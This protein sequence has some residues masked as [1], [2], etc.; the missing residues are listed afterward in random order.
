[1]HKSAVLLFLFLCSK[2][3]HAQLNPVNKT[4]PAQVK[5]AGRQTSSV[6]PAYLN[7]DPVL[8]FAF[9]TIADPDCKGPHC[10][11]WEYVTTTWQDVNTDA[12]SLNWK[13]AL[14]WRHIPPGAVFGKY[15]ISLSPFT[16]SNEIIQSGII[17]TGGKDSVLFTINYTEPAVGRGA[18]SKPVLKPV[19]NR[20]ASMQSGVQKKLIPLFATQEDVPFNRKF[21]IRITALNGNKNTTGNYSNEVW[22]IQTRPYFIKPKNQAPQITIYDDYTITSVKY[23]P[24]HFPEPSFYGCTVVTGY[25]ENK[26]EAYN[27]LLGKDFAQQFKQ[28]YPVGKTICPHYDTEGKP[29]YKKAFN[30]VT[31]FVGKAINGA[32][33]FYNDTKN[34]VKNKFADA[35]CSDNVVKN[36]AAGSAGSGANQTPNGLCKKVA[37]YAFDGAMVAA[38]IPP[39]LPNTDD[40]TKMAEGQLVDLACDKMEKESGIPVPDELREEMRKE[41]HQQ[42]QS[43]SSSRMV[44]CGFIRVKPHPQGFFQTAW[45]EIEVTRTSNNYK[46]KAIAG[47]GIQD[48]TERSNIYCEGC[49]GSD[50]NNKALSYNLFERAFT[51][52]PFLKNTGDKVKLVV[53]LKPQESWLQTNKA[54]GKYQRVDKAYPVNEWVNPVPPTYEGAASSSGFNTLCT[55][56]TIRFD[57]GGI[58]VA[59]GVQTIFFHK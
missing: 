21:Y 55:Q 27:K 9:Q 7:T 34:Y 38:G 17:E 29:W 28:A 5:T 32:S 22:L 56:S 47:I 53:V 30:G 40:L 20:P 33:E 18:G 43:S 48:K 3:L 1:M 19:T 25:D 39:S 14:L 58:K 2:S 15:E 10:L 44:D 45:L 8:H 41:F 52:V 42:V 13:Q 59:P 31:G 46:N 35:F 36:L 50:V 4:L 54:T 57:F 23:V 24:V 6:N 11:V 16:G 51:E 26:F 49:N 37:G 12:A